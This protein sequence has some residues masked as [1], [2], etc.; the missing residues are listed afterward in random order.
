MTLCPAYIDI[1]MGQS[2]NLNLDDEK[3]Q[4]LGA[5]LSGVVRKITVYFNN[6]RKQDQPELKLGP[7]HPTICLYLVIS[8]ILQRL[9]QNTGND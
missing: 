9:L 4:V 2:D 5:I 3:N 6:C 7:F 1:E 8:F